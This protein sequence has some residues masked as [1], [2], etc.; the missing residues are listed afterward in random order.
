[1]KEKLTVKGRKK[2]ENDIESLKAKLRRIREDKNYAYFNTGD[3]WHD[4]PMFVR[5]EQEEKQVYHEL[6]QLKKLLQ[7]AEIIDIADTKIEEVKIGAIFYA[8]AQSVGEKTTKDYFIEIVGK[9][10][11]DPAAQKISYDSPIGSKLEGKTRGDTV[12]VKLPKGEM[13]YVII[14]FFDNWESAREYRER[15]A[16]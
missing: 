5:L 16:I 1:M 3:N 12:K 6:I 7:S 14:E 9:A 8:R 10:E 2:L 4:N 13:E 11:S 15:N